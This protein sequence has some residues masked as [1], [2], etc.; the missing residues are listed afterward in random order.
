MLG[1]PPPAT[2]H[3]VCISMLGWRDLRQAMVL[4]VVGKGTSVAMNQEARAFLSVPRAALRA[5]NPQPL[6]LR[7]CPK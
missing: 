1:H 7:L 6:S 3:S 4:L 2:G 5:I